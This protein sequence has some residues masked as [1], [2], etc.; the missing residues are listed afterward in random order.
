MFELYGNVKQL[1]FFGKIDAIDIKGISGSGLE[2]ISFAS[3]V[4]NVRNDSFSVDLKKVCFAFNVRPIKN[5]LAPNHINICTLKML[6]T[7]QPPRP[8]ILIITKIN[9]IILLL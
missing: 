9:F 1:M 7:C 2:I 4:S 8:I 5:A 3:K 6:K